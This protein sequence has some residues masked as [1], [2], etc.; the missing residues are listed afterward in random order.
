MWTIRSLFTNIFIIISPPCCF[1]CKK[2]AYSLCEK[3]IQ[4]YRKCLNTSSPYIYAVFD[5]QDKNIKKIIHS[6]KYFHRKD[7]IIPIAS[8]VA[9]DLQQ[10]LST[11]LNREN[12]KLVPIPMP[13]LRKYIRGYNQA[14]KIA[15][16]FSSIWNIPVTTTILK[17]TKTSKRQVTTLS[18]DERLQNQKGTF[19]VV[20]DVRNMHIIIIDDVTTTGATFDEARK[21]LL[22][23]GAQSVIAVA[24][25][26]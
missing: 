6:I 1:S 17:R 24:L 20:S 14:E 23:N 21:I 25:A 13:S 12:I 4:N 15:E 19:T 7:L 2:E 9:S 26:H 18:R 16:V 8:Y 22:K 11:E 5:F 10:I 3:C